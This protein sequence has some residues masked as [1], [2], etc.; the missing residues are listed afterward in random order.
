MLV[1]SIDDAHPEANVT[2]LGELF[3]RMQ[4]LPLHELD[5]VSAAHSADPFVGEP[6]LNM[7]NL[8]RA[9]LRLDVRVL[10][11]P[12]TPTVRAQLDLAALIDQV[13]ASVLLVRV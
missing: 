6:A 9:C 3:A 8:I 1:V 10:V 11:L 4:G 12:D 2:R 5:F 13:P 7:A